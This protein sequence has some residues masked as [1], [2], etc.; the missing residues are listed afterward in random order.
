LSESFLFPE[1]TAMLSVLDLYYWLPTIVVQ[2]CCHF[3][4]VPHLAPGRS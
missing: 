4:Y 2:L 1:Q 3:P